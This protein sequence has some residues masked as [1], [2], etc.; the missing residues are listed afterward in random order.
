MVDGDKAVI[1]P[2]TATMT[3][4]E[5]IKEAKRKLNTPNEI[6]AKRRLFHISHDLMNLEIPLDP[7][8]PKEPDEPKPKAEQKQLSGSPVKKSE[9]TKPYGGKNSQ[10]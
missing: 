10:S 8:T 1:E 4:K 2:R 7:E 9:Q 6:N 5:Q 3:Q